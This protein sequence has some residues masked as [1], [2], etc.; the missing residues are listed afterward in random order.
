MKFLRRVLIAVVVAV[1]VVVLAIA[2]FLVMTPRAPAHPGEVTTPAEL[3]AYLEALVANET[4]PAIEV[5]VLK[6]G[7]TVYSKAFGKSDV[8]GKTAAPDDVFHFW[9]VTKLFTA[10]AVMQL[11][12]DGKLSLDDPVTR[13]VPD[14]KTTNKSGAPVYITIRQLLDHT[15]GMK[16]LGP[17]DLLGWI[18]HLTDPPVD[19]ASIVRDRM[20]AYKSLA[21]HP[22]QNWLIYQRR[23]HCARRCRAGRLRDDL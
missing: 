7:E 10:T 9:S 18:H 22:W 21:E 23:L 1:G 5:T 19:Q 17:G 8:N 20:A 6:D 12:E 11:A 14:F 16:D 3:D 15:S 4:P 13:H 2:P